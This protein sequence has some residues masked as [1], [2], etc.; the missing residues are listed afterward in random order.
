MALWHVTNRWQA[1]MR[2]ALAPHGLT[3]VQY[4]LLASLVWLHSVEPDRQMTQAALAEH[5]ATDVMMTSQVL[6]ALE[7]KGMVERARHPGDGR[8]RILRPTP[9]GILAARAA[10]GDVEAADASF[11]G[12]LPELGA[13]T[14]ALNLLS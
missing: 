2:A 13:F 4:V 6:R 10:T 5:T 1:V 9:R 8:A 11:F 12:R 3:H 7:A 14:D